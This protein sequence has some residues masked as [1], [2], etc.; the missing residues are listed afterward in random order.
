MLLFC[1]CYLFLCES[2]LEKNVD[3][4]VKDK[5]SVPSPFNHFILMSYAGH[6]SKILMDL[7]IVESSGV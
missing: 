1:C 3:L 5:G 6:Y 4:A 2:H 7:M